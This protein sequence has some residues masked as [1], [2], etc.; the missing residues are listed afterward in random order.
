MIRHRFEPARLLL[1]LVLL[2]AAAAYLM[3]ASGEWEVPF[4]VLLVLMPLAL[5]MAGF[6]ALM[7]FLARRFLDRKR[8]TAPPP[9]GDLP[10]DDLR[11]GYEHPAGFARDSAPRDSAPQGREGREGS[12]P[13]DRT[14]P[15]ASGSGRN[16]AGSGS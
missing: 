11:R 9:L 8:E 10:V 14:P 16:G 1:G 7:T 6:T 2:F 15:D 13:E 4:W 5:L 3:D 12:A